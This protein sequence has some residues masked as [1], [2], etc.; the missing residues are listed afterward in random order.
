MIERL[1]GTDNPIQPRS[2]V[3]EGVKVNPIKVD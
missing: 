2:A 3:H 1:I